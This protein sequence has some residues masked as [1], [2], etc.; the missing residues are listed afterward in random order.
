VDPATGRP[1]ETAEADYGREAA[2]IWP[3][4]LGGHNW[5]PMSFNPETGLVYV[6]VHDLPGAHAIDPKWR[7]RKESWNTG[8]ALDANLDIP[9]GWSDMVAGRLIAWDPVAQREV[10]RADHV[11]AWNG[12]TLTTAGNLVF[13]G[14][15]DGRFVAFRA[16]DGEP[17]W[18]SP[19]GTGVIAAPITY[20]VD[21]EQ[22]VTVMAG[23]GGAFPLAYGEA[24][25]KAGV[26]SIGRMLTFR[27]GGTAQLPPAIPYVSTPAAPPF[28]VTASAE[29]LREGGVAYH[30][31][32]S[33]CHG[34]KAVGGGVVPDL[35]RASAE[36][37]AQWNAIVLGGI[38]GA[39][40]M[41]S[42]ADVLDARQAQLI[43]QYV[44][45]RI[46]ETQP[47]QQATP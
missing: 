36:T 14:T 8:T 15:A 3:S 33:V 21:G 5:Q 24:G 26:T 41:V 1:I 27:I 45:Q 30:E 34:L 13:E 17:L 11:T 19:A 12:G 29:E 31:W 44:V 9:D 38:R 20:L 47:K 39:Q 23:W 35:R 40:G 2:F 42:F 28:A 16:S 10:W 4:P 37:H 25:A 7:H 6:P 43:Q 32:C 22:F 18:E 46:W